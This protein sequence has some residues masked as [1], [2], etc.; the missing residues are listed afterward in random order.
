MNKNN[1]YKIYKI[2]FKIKLKQKII[3]II[4]FKIKIFMLK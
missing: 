3:N 1:K 4:I 2:V